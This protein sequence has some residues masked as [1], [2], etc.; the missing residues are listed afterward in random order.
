MI[1][2]WRI[3]KAERRDDVLM[4]EGAR[5]FGGRWNSPGIPVVYTAEHRSLAMLET[6]VHIPQSAAIGV[7]L[8]FP[9]SFDESLV[10]EI[11]LADLP[12]GWDS[13]PPSSISQSVGNTWAQANR[14]LVL[15][16]PSALVPE[17]RNYLINPHHP[18]FS[19][20]SIGDSATC[21][22]DPRLL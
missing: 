1:E 18:K 22:F 4:G 16:V 5:I 14:S 7:Y 6:L 2:S 13:E 21:R 10:E 11:E 15:A 19:T 3:V 17:E 20:V 8:M 9:V 12:Q